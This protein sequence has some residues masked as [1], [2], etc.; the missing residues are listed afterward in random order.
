LRAD[1]EVKSVDEPVSNMRY[2]IAPKIDQW[3]I[4]LL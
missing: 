2:Y 4:L 1:G 3:I